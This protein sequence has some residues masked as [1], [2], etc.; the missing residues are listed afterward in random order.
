MK[1]WKVTHRCPI[2]QRQCL[3]VAAT[4]NKMAILIATALLGPGCC[5]VVNVSHLMRTGRYT[6]C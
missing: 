2:Q 6:W 1:L 5:S 4:S 3:H